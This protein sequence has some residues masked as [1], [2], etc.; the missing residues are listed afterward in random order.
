MHFFTTTI[1]RT[2]IQLSLWAF[3]LIPSGLHA[4]ER[5]HNILVLHSYHAGLAWTDG[6]QRGIEQY[7]DNSSMPV[8]LYVEY[9]DTKRNPGNDYLQRYFTLLQYKL[10]HL[11]FD[12]V[13]VTDNDAY[14]L[15]LQ[16]RNDLFADRPIVFCGVNDFHPRDVTAEQNITGVAEDLSV[17][18]TLDVALSL[19]PNSRELIL[20]GSRLGATGPGHKSRYREQPAPL[21][22]GPQNHHMARY[23]HRKTAEKSR[24]PQTGTTGFPQQCVDPP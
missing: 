15:A 10:R 4:Q 2:I 20:I 24:H 19:H 18:E 21:Q 16:H 7:F 23:P 9:M 12:L 3:L 14:N 17:E 11:D 6:L 22:P 13:L 8:H 5:L 1:L